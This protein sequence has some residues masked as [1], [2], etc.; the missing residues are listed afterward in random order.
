MRRTAALA[1]LL[2]LAVLLTGCAP[3]HRT[4]LTIFAASS[5]TESFTELADDFEKTHPDVD[6]VLNFGGS[7]GLAEQIVEGAPADVFAAASPDPMQTVA[8]SAEQGLAD[9]ASHAD[10]FATNTLEIAVPPGNPGGVHGL[11]DFA[12]PGLVIAQCAAEVPCGAAAKTVQSAAGVRASVDS[13]EQDVKSVLTKVELGEVDAGIVYRTDVL[14]AGDRVQG[15]AIANAD[16][17]VA[18]Y[19]IVAVSDTQAARDFVALVLSDA[20]QRVLHNHGFAP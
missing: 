8:H 16:A 17:A 15:I 2:L 3:T 10:V 13:Y 6:V 12:R 5:L 18:R 11:S 9:R 1:S 4:T 19:P 20:G 14:A 7:S